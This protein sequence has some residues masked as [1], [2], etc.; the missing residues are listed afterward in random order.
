MVLQKV[1]LA[2]ALLSFQDVGATV[3]ITPPPSESIVSTVQDRR[4]DIKSGITG[5]TLIR[6]VRPHATIGTSTSQPFQ[7]TIEVLDNDGRRVT[8][9]ETDPDGK[10][11][12]PLPPGI[13][14]V[15]PL[16]ASTYPRAAEQ[17]VTVETDSF[18]PLRMIY[19]SGIR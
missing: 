9:L 3:W 4:V 5:E 17:P 6:P 11:R 12:V 2:L 15:R 10:F 19:D 8:T 7:T 14:R 13:Y 1:L 18:T 16:S